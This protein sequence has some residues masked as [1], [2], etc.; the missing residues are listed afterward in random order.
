MEDETINKKKGVIDYLQS[1]PE[2]FFSAY[3]IE[4]TIDSRRFQMNYNN[5]LLRK[6]RENVTEYELDSSGFME[7]S[8][9][10]DTVN[11]RVYF[12]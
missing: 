2:E 11:I 8:F 3:A 6:Y 10:F 1:I 9:K 12:T 5:V 7:V 4:V